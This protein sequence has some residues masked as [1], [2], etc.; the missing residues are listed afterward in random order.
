MYCLDT[1]IIIDI[2]R[3]DENIISK[4]EKYWDEQIF[5]TSITLCELY[6]GAYVHKKSEQKLKILEEFLKNVEVISEDVYSCQQFGLIWQKLKKKGTQINDFDIMIA[7]IVK[8]HNLTLITRDK[9]FKNLDIKTKI[10]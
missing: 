9:H 5:I 6:K 3:R 4:I 10:I 1:N 2:F 7:S 8:S